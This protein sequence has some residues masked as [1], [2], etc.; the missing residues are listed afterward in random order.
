MIL[1]FPFSSYWVYREIL[2]PPRLE[3]FGRI[4]MNRRDLKSEKEGM[5]IEELNSRCILSISTARLLGQFQGTV[6]CLKGGII[7]L[8]IRYY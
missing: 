2:R 3:K 5:K 8:S 7:Y 6:M 1:I 4:R